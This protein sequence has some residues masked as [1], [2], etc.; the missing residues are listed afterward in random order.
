MR[1]FRK[2][3]ARADKIFNKKAYEGTNVSLTPGTLCFFDKFKITA[4]EIKSRYSEGNEKNSGYASIEFFHT[5]YV[6][7]FGRPL[8]ETRICEGEEVKITLGKRKF[9]IW[10]FYIPVDN[11]LH[12]KICKLEYTG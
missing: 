10:D 7:V 4:T 6:D 8:S 1:V 12:F 11:Q 9:R 5:S 2:L 3:A